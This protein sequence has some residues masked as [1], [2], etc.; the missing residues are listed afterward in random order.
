MGRNGRSVEKNS[1]RE[2]TVSRDK[3][4]VETNGRKAE[5]SVETKGG[6]AGCSVETNSQ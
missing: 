2:W 3:R 5:W 1:G 4:S 6:K